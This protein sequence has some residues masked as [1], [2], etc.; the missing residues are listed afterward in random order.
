MVLPHQIPH[1]NGTVAEPVL[2]GYHAIQFGLARQL[3][4]LS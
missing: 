4:E 2:N 3:L 1:G